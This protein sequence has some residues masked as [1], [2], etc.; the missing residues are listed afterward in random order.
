M[1][2]SDELSKI[3]NSK[4]SIADTVK[5]LEMVKSA[6]QKSDKIQANLD[7]VQQ[8][9]EVVRSASA[10]FVSTSYLTLKFEEFSD[11]VDKM[12]SQKFND[13]SQIFCT[14][15]D[16]KVSSE[17]LTQYLQKKVG[18]SQ[19]SPISQQVSLLQ[20]RV[21]KHIYSDF[22]GFKT[23]I[24]L[25]LASK[26]NEAKSL[27]VN[28]EEFA[29]IKSKIV[30]MEQKLEELFMEDDA[31]QDDEY[32]SQEEMDNMM[33]DIDMV[34]KREDSI[35]AEVEA[36]QSTSADVDQ[37]IVGKS[38]SSL[39]VETKNLDQV[40]DK[41]CESPKIREIEKPVSRQSRARGSS[42]G[43]DSRTMQRRG[44]KESS[45][46]ASRALGGGG[47][48]QVYRK[49]T[50]LQKE[51]ESNKVEIEDSKK[52][53]RQ[54]EESLE[55]SKAFSEELQAKIKEMHETLG[56]MENSFIRA[57]RRNGIDKKVKPKEVVA[58]GL[59]KKEIDSID[60]KID[61]KFKRII[62]LETDVDRMLSESSLLKKF[63]KEKIQEIFSSLRNLEDFK[64]KVSK[65]LENLADVMQRNFKS[66]QQSL[67]EFSKKVSSFN[68]PLVDLISDQ[69][70]ENLVLC[71]E[72]RRHQELFRAMVEEYS[73]SAGNCRSLSENMDLVEYANR[74]TERQARTGRRH[75]ATP[76]TSFKNKC[77]QT[78]TSCKYSKR[79]DSEWMRKIPD[80]TPVSLPRVA[81]VDK[82]MHKSYYKDL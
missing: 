43:G 31:M 58:A 78:G 10:S 53:T 44:S 8:D 32:D 21:D 67:E 15:L 61:E 20:S 82:L 39:K 6:F 29:Q 69:K 34:A 59:G 4:L 36:E 77:Y 73:V 50:A 5:Q 68:S 18:W 60:K 57:L 24:K 23:K 7:K 38:E 51:L 40:D 63:V 35:S 25:E 9:L 1:E 17:S 74:F 11:A 12:I 75:C 72:V 81:A 62:V 41:K 26:A 64:S 48:K 52:Y 16:S 46:A 76:E 66:N 79:N 65:D 55:I 45:I 42:I 27:D 56:V 70:R 13:F 28:G 71:E 30:V 22:E 49:I 19:F 33:E 54:V 2:L 37:S 47:M 14:Q 80:G 3:S